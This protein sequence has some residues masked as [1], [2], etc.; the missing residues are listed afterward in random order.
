MNNPRR[1]RRGLGWF[2]LVERQGLMASLCLSYIPVLHSRTETIYPG[3][4]L[5]LKYELV[6]K[7]IPGDRE[8]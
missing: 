4:T 3:T 1:E 8:P 7:P 2:Y 5:R 6:S